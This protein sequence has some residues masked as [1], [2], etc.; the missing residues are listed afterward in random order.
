MGG[1]DT[2]RIRRPV[3]GMR[4]LHTLRMGGTLSL[5][6]MNMNMDMETVRINRIRLG[7]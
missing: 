7:I 5:I 3:R 6:L 1:T 4:R 2:S